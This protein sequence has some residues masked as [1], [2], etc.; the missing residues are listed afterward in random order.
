MLHKIRLLQ[1]CLLVSILVQVLT[2]TNSCKSRRVVAEDRL[3]R[4]SSFGLSSVRSLDYGS[5][6]STPQVQCAA[7]CVRAG[8]LFG[9]VVSAPTVSKPCLL[10]KG[11]GSSLKQNVNPIKTSFPSH[12]P[13]VRARR[14]APPTSDSGKWR[15]ETSQEAMRALSEFKSLTAPRV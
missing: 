15:P 5:T 2:A 13:R 8:Q 10:Q 7:T 12:R 11:V 14:L 6:M 9:R 3:R 4:K 1:Q